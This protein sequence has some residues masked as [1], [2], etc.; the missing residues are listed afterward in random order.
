MNPAI[1]TRRE[2]RAALANV[3]ILSSYFPVNDAYGTDTCI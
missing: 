1:D 2:L 3:S